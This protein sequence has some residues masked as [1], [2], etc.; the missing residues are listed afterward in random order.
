MPHYSPQMEQ[1]N[2]QTTVPRIGLLFTL[3]DRCCSNNGPGQMGH[4]VLGLSQII[5]ELTSVANGGL[6][7]MRIVK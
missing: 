6:N 2:L 3:R 1:F 4:I 7:S 5:M